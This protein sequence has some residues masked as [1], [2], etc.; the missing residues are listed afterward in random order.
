MSLLN[1]KSVMTEIANAMEK[2]RPG[3]NR[4]VVACIASLEEDQ[5]FQRA[6]TKMGVDWI[7]PKVP[8]VTVS[9]SFASPAPAGPSL[10]KK[11][12]YF[13]SSLWRSEKYYMVSRAIGPPESGTALCVGEGGSFVFRRSHV[14]PEDV[15]DFDAEIVRSCARDDPGLVWD[16][17]KLGKSVDNSPETP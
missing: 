13:R 1:L 9:T 7:G 6:A 11:P 3:S 5:E 12:G 4:T 2:E 10:P 16:E 8:N 15:A 14:H 17:E